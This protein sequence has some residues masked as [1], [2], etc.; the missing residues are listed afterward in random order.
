MCVEKLREADQSIRRQVS[1][2]NRLQVLDEI[3]GV[4]GEEER[5]LDGD[6]SMLRLL[7]L[8]IFANI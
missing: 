7:S 4:R 8:E 5:Y 3:Y 6:P 2:A 1:P